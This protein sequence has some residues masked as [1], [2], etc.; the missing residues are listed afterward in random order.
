MVNN[1]KYSRCFPLN[2]FLD[3]VMKGLDG[4]LQSADSLAVHHLQDQWT[5][6][7]DSLAAMLASTKT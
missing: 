7:M 4:L 1:E 3:I 6:I 2:P 5:V